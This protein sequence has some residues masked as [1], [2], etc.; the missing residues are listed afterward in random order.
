M[1][2]FRIAACKSITMKKVL[3]ILTALSIT[4]IANVSFAAPKLNSLSGAD[5]VIFLDFD[6]HFV[7]GTLWNNGQSFN[8]SAANLTDAQIKK[9]FQSVAED[10]RPFKINITTDSISFL[11]AP[12]NRRMRII[13]TP[14]S[15]WKN[16]VNGI[17]FIGSF[18]WGDDTPGFVFSDKLSNNPK[19]IAECCSH[20]S[21]HTLGLAHQSN[22]D[23]NCNMTETYHSGYGS[24]ETSWAPIMGNSYQK[25]MT[26]WNNGATP[27]GCNNTQDNLTLIAE[28][29]DI[30]FRE[31]DYSDAQDNSSFGIASDDFII[32]GMI[33][34]SRD[35]DVFKLDINR[36]TVLQVMGVPYWE[37]NEVDN[38][39]LD[40]SIMLYNEAHT[41]VKTFDPVESM[42]VGFETYL[43][44]GTYYMVIDGV[45][46]RFAGEYGSLG[47]YSIT[48]TF[49]TPDAPK[50]MLSGKTKFGKD[51]LEWKTTAYE[52][53]ISEQL[54]FS[55]DGM[56]FTDISV[57]ATISKSTSLSSGIYQNRY[58]RVK[59][60]LSSG[61]AVYSNTVQLTNAGFEV[62][63][64]IQSQMIVHAKQNYTYLMSD[65]NGRILL[66]GNGNA[67]LNTTNVSN[68]ASGT[69]VLTLIREGEK[70][71]MRI[72]KQ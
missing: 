51:M 71:S 3:N 44:A 9:I 41:L 29:N 47:S 43:K 23:N 28:V 50:V 20:E 68:L 38:A 6:G 40:I 2:S 39:D 4:F 15:Q 58:Y 65:I 70:T 45:G 53:T 13:V 56:M 32:K 69:Y 7:E 30:A 35:K 19:Y 66:K 24:G 26:G 18:V 60:T 16:G 25:N 52:E 42:S 64:L 49:K 21:G 46:N 67:G 48:G 12:I 54:E 14:T 59:S 55:T 27:Y 8:C 36:E 33:N 1:L 62:A 5:A 22:Y 57:L 37:G 31:D 10:F 63:T 34:T 17:S 61:K 11:N 72:L